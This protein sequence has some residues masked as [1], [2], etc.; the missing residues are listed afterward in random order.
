MTVAPIVSKPLS[1]TLPMPPM[2]FKIRQEGMP[3]IVVGAPEHTRSV[4]EWMRYAEQIARESAWA[5]GKPVEVTT[6]A[7][8]NQYV[9]YVK[10]IRRG[11]HV[12]RI[13]VKG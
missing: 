10:F 13:S 8:G 6:Y 3:T 1:R 5:S 11:A 7:G 12:A 2:P 9:P 4:S